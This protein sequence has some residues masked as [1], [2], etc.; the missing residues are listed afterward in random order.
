VKHATATLNTQNAKN[1]PADT[2]RS[3]GL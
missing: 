3:Q 2:G 1:R